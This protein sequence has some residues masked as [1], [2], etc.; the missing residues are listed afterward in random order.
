MSNTII[1]SA[2]ALNFLEL[3]STHEDKTIVEGFLAAVDAMVKDYCGRQFHLEESAEEIL[4]GNDGFGVGKTDI[5][6]ADYPVSNVLVY[7]DDDG[8]KTFT[9]ADLVDDESYAVHEDIGV[10]DFYFTLPARYKNIKVVY[11]RGY[12]DDDMPE[13]LKFVCKLEV[14]N[15][16]NRWKEDS[17]N[18]ENYSVAGLRK[19]FYTDLSPYS[20][21]MLD[22]FFVKKRA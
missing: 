17:F 22:G 20:K 13:N 16:Y 14:K 1:S 4:D 11:D 10:I 18:V 19:D 12:S 2:E 15:L 9:D 3:S 21:M 5:F 8:D 6:L 7:I